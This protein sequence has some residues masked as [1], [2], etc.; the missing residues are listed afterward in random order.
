MAHKLTL[1]LLMLLFYTAG[2]SQQLTPRAIN[3]AGQSS[4]NGGI[5][6][7][8]AVGGFLV[9]SF[10]TPTFLYTQDILQPDAGTSS[11]AV[12]INDV[13]LDGNYVLDNAGTTLITSNTMLEF[14]I[15]EPASITLN[16][17]NNLLTQGVLQPYNSGTVLPITSLDFYAKRISNTQVQLDWKTLQE[18]NN[19][20]FNIE[21]KQENEN[22]FIDIGIVNSKGTNGNSNI[23]LDYQKIDDN[24]FTGNTYYRLKQEDFDGKINYSL[25]RMVKGSADKLLN[26][27]VWP[28]PAVGFFN[29]RISGLDKS[30]VLQ[31]IDMN[32]RLIKQFAIQNNL[33]QQVNGLPAGTYFIKLASD[34]NVGQKVIM[35]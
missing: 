27:Q 7:E 23:A 22:G 30:D 29:V 24:N 11:A 12:Y 18:I 20:G 33:Q 31:V 4:S 35:Q 34:K 14:S 10:S 28:V 9:N 26:M 5:I 19:K 21:R 32:G 8:D 2:S 3:A 6:L 15:G 13:K 17:P 1:L 25:V 16:S